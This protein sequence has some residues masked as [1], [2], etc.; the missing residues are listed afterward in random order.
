[1]GDSPLEGDVRFH[2]DRAIAYAKWLLAQDPAHLD[3]SDRRQRD[4]L[5]SD[6][7][8]MVNLFKDMER[9]ARAN[10][11]LKAYFT[12][13]LTAHAVC[14]KIFGRMLPQRLVEG[15]WY[16]F[17]AAFILS[18]GAVAWWWLWGPIVSRGLSK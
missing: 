16:G 6:G 14:L 9:E 17:W 4:F 15:L 7:K 10:K 18:I 1:M 3:E 11:D 12:Y 5:Q 8:E 2:P 13:L